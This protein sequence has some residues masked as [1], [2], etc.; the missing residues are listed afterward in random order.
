VEAVE[1]IDLILLPHAD[2]H[3]VRDGPPAPTLK[4]DVKLRTFPDPKIPDA[5]A[6]TS[7]LD[8]AK[9]EVQFTFFAPH[10]GTPRRFEGVPKV[11]ADGTVDVS[12]ADLGVYLFQV[13][14]V[15]KDSGKTNVGAVVGRLQVHKEFDTWWFGND[16]ITTALDPRFAHAQPSIYARFRDDPSGAD[17]I[18]DITGHGYVK[19]V[20]NSASVVIDAAGRLKG[21]AETG[22]TTPATITGTFLEAPP[23]SRPPLTLSAR[24]VDYGKS[25]AVL[26]PVRNPDLTHLDTK[27][28]IVFLAEG[29]RETDR[30]LFNK[31]VE[32]TAR[33]MFTQ[34]RHEPYGLLKGSFNVFRAFAASQDEQATCGFPVTDNDTV[35]GVKG[36][37]IPSI[38]KFR[39]AVRG[40]Y[41]LKQLVEIVGLPRRGEARSPKQ[42][43]DFW[44]AQ[45]IPGFELGKTDPQLV[46][47]WKAHRAD[48]FLRA[49]DTIFGMYLGS[50]WADGST[51]ST[52]QTVA[53]PIP[54]GD[55]P[56][57][58]VEGPKLAALITRL[59]AFYK[60]RL[61]QE[62]T[63]DPRRHAPELYA[64]SGRVNPGSA[65]MSYLGGLQ[66][67]FPPN[68]PIGKTWVPDGGT[69]KPSVGLVSI[70]TYDEV[71]GGSAINKNSLTASTL[72][73][74]AVVRFTPDGLH[75]ELFRRIAPQPPTPANR[76]GIVKLD[77]FI[78][79]AA[80]EFGHVFDLDDEYELFGLSEDPPEALG[81][82]DVEAD[83]L[84][85]IGFLRILPAP[86]RQ[87]T[88]SRVK[89]LTLPRI[90]L[91]SRLLEATVPDTLHPTQITV[92]VGPDE[93]AKWVAV[94]KA[95][96][97]VSLL[98]R[99]GNLTRQQLPLPRP[100]NVDHLTGLRII[101]T[102]DAVRG[103]FVLNDPSGLPIKQTFR[104]GSVLYVQRKNPSGTPSFV[105]EDEVA[106]FLRETALPL[107]RN[108]SLTV[109]STDDQIPLPIFNFK[110]PH[111]AF[112]LVG[113][114]EGGKHVSRGFYRPTGACKMRNQNDLVHDGR[115]FC[116]VCKWLLVNLVDGGQHALL[117]RDLYPKRPR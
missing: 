112:R 100:G 1:N 33:D 82:R 55:A 115:Q 52:T 76:T 3:V 97:A 108:R 67:A 12:Q 96:L 93:L 99:T 78:N 42:L 107:N 45:G 104:E 69:P 68:Q 110:P 109:P 8:P 92:T 27:S 16:S 57:D 22:T 48:G 77:A 61:P 116:H 58:P 65:I 56:G 31:V 4:L 40:S 43:T 80:H 72:A 81:A 91:S 85:S 32:D 29:F 84:A 24:V 94:Q 38:P 11:A 62:L 41:T 25:R 79:K 9:F 37:P 23:L 7:V 49:S 63:L 13:G 30:A 70:V 87:L 103:S 66:Y 17:L 21:L 35:F 88:I 20:S 53:A 28:N 6:L 89:W 95:G 74:E 59:Y 18:G 51:V 34:P 75:P 64:S 73:D 117:D 50:R 44:T 26:E 83:N 46:E 19:L 10:N 105:V 36:V 106:A 54:A 90:T 98:N 5:Y 71:N 86:G 114:Y 111:N 47:A 2:L 14:V 39:G 60:S 101:G 113:I 15:K 102:P